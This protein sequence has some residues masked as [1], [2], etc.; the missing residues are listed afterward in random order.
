MK[1]R[2]TFHPIRWLTFVLVAVLLPFWVL[3][4]GSTLLIRL[5][6]VNAWLAIGTSALGTSL[7]LGIYF[8][9]LSRRLKIKPGRWIPRFSLLLVGLYCVYGL[10]ALS[11]AHV[12]NPEIRDTYGA[13]HPVIRLALATVVLVDDEM[14]VTASGRVPED[15]ATMGLPV[16][17]RSL[18]FSQP[19]GFVHA[20]DLRT[21]GR[22]EWQNVLAK[23]YF[24]SLGLS[25][26]RH[27]GT[28]DHLHVS[29]RP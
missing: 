16:Y 9:F 22:P 1:S 26:L 7:L 4:L 15:Y 12:K 11:P 3:L 14:V 18:H 24:R 5:A 6:E 28:A 21:I 13:L 2:P 8:F 10:I 17:D 27:V 19:D 29:L 20:V 25:V 23:L